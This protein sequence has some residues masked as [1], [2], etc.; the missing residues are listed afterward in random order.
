[1]AK[2]RQI[3]PLTRPQLIDKIETVNLNTLPP[4]SNLFFHG[5]QV[6][7]LPR[8]ELIAT[9]YTLVRI[10]EKMKMEAK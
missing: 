6:E 5:R 7:Q 4:V 3:I 2:Q 10:M 8:E 1:M 9:I